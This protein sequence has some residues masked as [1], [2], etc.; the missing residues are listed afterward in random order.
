MTKTTE[1]RCRHFV[2]GEQVRAGLGPGPGEATPRGVAGVCVGKA[3]L[4]D[5]QK[6]LEP[7]RSAAGHDPGRDPGF[8]CRRL[9]GVCGRGEG[10]F[11][12]VGVEVGPGPGIVEREV[13]RALE[14]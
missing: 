2:Q 7:W 11:E 9:V 12:E 10:P 13:G 4:R 1:G 14:P 8:L 5:L 3:F 6:A